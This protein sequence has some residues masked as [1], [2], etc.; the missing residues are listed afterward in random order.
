MMFFAMSATAFLREG[1]SQRK[2][3]HSPY[4]ATELQGSAWVLADSI[5]A[6]IQGG[7]NIYDQAGRP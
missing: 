7:Q 6:R 5:R 3:N 1:L 2:Y 4:S